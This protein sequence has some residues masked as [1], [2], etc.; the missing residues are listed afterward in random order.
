MIGMVC[1]FS[2][3]RLTHPV[4]AMQILENVR[5]QMIRPTANLRKPANPEAD[6]ATSK[7]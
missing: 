7:E 5:K 6:S 1:L 2:A 4:G 3:L